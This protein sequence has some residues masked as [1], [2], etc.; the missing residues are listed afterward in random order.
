MTYDNIRK[1]GNAG[2]GI[3]V[4]FTWFWSFLMSIEV[5]H[6]SWLGFPCI[7]GSCF[8]GWEFA[9]THV[10]VG[11]WKLGVILL[12]AL[13]VLF[14]VWICQFNYFNNSVLLILFQSWLTY[15]LRQLCTN[16]VISVWI[17]LLVS[18]F[19]YLLCMAPT[20]YFA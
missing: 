7:W 5:A 10:L 9:V 1:R 13:Y 6:N 4:V 16:L 12:D 11:F 14:F 18:E 2:S 19:E 17:Y 3:Y 20:S 15:L 8:G